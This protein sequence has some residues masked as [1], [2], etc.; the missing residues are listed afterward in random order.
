MKRGGGGWMS[1]WQEE[2]VFLNEGMFWRFEKRV[3]VNSTKK[4]RVVKKKRLIP[5]SKR[6]KRVEKGLFGLEERTVWQKR[7]K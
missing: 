4:K 3:K 7:M 5:S 2:N 1:S 6:G